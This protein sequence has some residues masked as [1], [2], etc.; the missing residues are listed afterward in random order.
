MEIG[1]GEIRVGEPADRSGVS[2][3]D[4]SDGVECRVLS[5]QGFGVLILHCKKEDCEWQV[6]GVEIGEDEVNGACD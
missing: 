6:V 1:K 3:S 4:V 2:S 5:S